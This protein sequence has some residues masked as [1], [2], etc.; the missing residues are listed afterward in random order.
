MSQNGTNYTVWA[1]ITGNSASA[2]VNITII[3]EPY[4]LPNYTAV[5]LINNSE[6]SV[7]SFTNMGGTVD[8]WQVDPA[9]PAGLTLDSTGNITG[10]PTVVQVG[11]NYT[12]WGNNTGGSDSVVVNITIGD[13]PS[14]SPDY[15]EVVLN[16]TMAMDPI[17][18]NSTGG[19]IHTWEVEPELPAGLSLNATGVING[20]P[21]EIQIGINYTIWA[22]T[23]LVQIQSL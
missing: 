11:T 15:T 19:M 10:T 9:L 21:T 5:T 13:L 22:T 7:I 8:T 16:R 23:P 12:I 18:F 20:T 1:N 6:M 14:I 2:I 4:L 3:E 17:I